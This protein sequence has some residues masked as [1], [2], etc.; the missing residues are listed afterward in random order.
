MQAHDTTIRT[1]RRLAFEW[2]RQRSRGRS[3]LARHRCGDRT[4]RCR[5]RQPATNDLPTSGRGRQRISEILAAVYLTTPTQVYTFVSVSGATPLVAERRRR[6][7]T[8]WL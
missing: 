5:I 2:F 7:L 3:M 4:L 1:N 8:T 6:S